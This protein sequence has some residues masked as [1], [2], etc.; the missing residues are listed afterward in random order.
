MYVYVV[1]VETGSSYE[2][3]A[4]VFDSVWRSEEEAKEYCKGFKASGFMN[5]G[6]EY[7]IEKVLLNG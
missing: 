3:G 2:E 1:E 7:S 4:M 5:P 6:R